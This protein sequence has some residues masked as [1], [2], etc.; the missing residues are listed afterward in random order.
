MSSDYQIDIDAQ[1]IQDSA[2]E[3]NEIYEENEKI[4]AQQKEQELL[5]Q[6]QQEQATAEFKDP[7][8]KEGGGGLR[9]VSKEIRCAIG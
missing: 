2:L 6:Q 3:F 5:L 9:G 1:A 8:D 7:R 4:E